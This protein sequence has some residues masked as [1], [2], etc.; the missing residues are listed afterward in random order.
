MRDRVSPQI[1]DHIMGTA[2]SMFDAKHGGFGSA[3][4]FPHSSAI[5]LLLHRYARTGDPD[6]GN[7]CVTTLETW[8]AA[9]FTTN[10]RADSIATR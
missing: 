5:D 10:S 8:R 4:K 6:V 9:E 1:V 7:I 2:Q 3:P